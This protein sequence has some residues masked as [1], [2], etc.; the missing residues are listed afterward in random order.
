MDVN[1]L[2]HT[3]LFYTILHHL[4]LCYTCSRSFTILCY[5]TILHFSTPPYIFYT[6]VSYLI[7]H[8]PALFCTILQYSLLSFTILHY[9][10]LFCTILN[11]ASLPRPA[12]Q[13]DSLIRREPAPVQSGIC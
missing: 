13:R 4:T 10:V 1:I 7:S 6:I 3:I 5:P 2:R 12:P 8:Y 9:P 11:Y